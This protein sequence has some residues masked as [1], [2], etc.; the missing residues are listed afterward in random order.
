MEEFIRVRGAR[1]HNLKDIDLDIPRGKV[2]VVTGPSGSGKSSLVMDTIYAEGQRRYIESLSTYAKQFLEQI[3]KPDV[4]KVDGVSPAV[5][6]EQRNQVKTSRST[7]GTV[8]EVYDFMRILW[9]R[10]GRTFCPA[11]QLEVQPDTIDWAT[12]QVLEDFRGEAVQITFPL[13]LSRQIS[14]T[15]AVNNLQ[16]QGYLRVLADGQEVYLPDQ[17]DNPQEANPDIDITQA[18]ELLV[19]ADRLQVQDT[20]EARER[21]SDGLSASYAESHGLAVVINREG[22]RQKFSER[23]ECSRC[24]EEF[25]RP[26]PALFSFNSSRGACPECEGFGATLEYDPGLIVP[27]PEQTIRQGAIKVWE[28]PRYGRYKKH[29]RK[30]CQRH[31]INI[32]TPFRK[33]PA[34]KQELLLQGGRH[35]QGVIPFLE[36]REEKKY[37]RHIRFMLR[38]YQ[39]PRRCPLCAGE[40]LRSEALNVYVG[41]ENQKLTI[42]EAAQLKIDKL[43]DWLAN[44]ELEGFRQEVAGRLHSEL[45]SRIGFLAHVGLGYLTL[46]RQA[47]TL[48]G[49]EMQ[50]IR[51]ARCLGAGLTDTLYVLDEPTIGLHPADM[52]RFLEAMERF[53]ELGNTVLMVE[54]EPRVMKEAD[55]IV[56]L[57]P[58]SGEQGGEVVFEGT[59]SELLE[60]DTTTGQALRKRG[61]GI[62]REHKGGGTRKLSLQGASLHNIHDLDVQIPLERFVGVSG[63]SGSGKSTLVH[64]LL[65]HGLEKKLTGNVSAREHLG[66]DVGEYDQLTGTDRISEVVLVD[67]S[68]VGKS[69]RS[70]PATFVKAFGGIR[71]L[72]AGTEMARRRGFDQSAFSFNTEGGRC[73]ECKGTGEKEVDM[74][75]MADVSVPCQTCQGKRFHE[76]LLEVEYQGHNMHD[77]LQM[78]VDEAVKFFNTQDSIARSLWQLQRVGLGYIRLGQPIN[79]LSGGENQRLKIARELARASG[80]KG[81]FYILDEPTIGLG[82]S[83]ITQLVRWVISELVEAGHTVLVIEHNLDVLQSADW[84]IDLGPG[85]AEAGGEV[86]ACGPPAAIRENEHSR[87]GKYL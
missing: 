80:D 17:P 46:D 7:V 57:G 55:W 22:R 18:Q 2:T 40:R 29:M 63:V 81:R 77:I 82:L 31:D 86:V 33:L 9:A 12:Q 70:I 10:A 62:E 24:G 60:A 21:I 78:T 25:P 42:S 32:D 8:T 73:Q 79:T 65:F 19:V 38:R 69:K 14:H 1:Q 5:A 58:R 26:R 47:R 20:E 83:E 34:Q 39:S 48:S 52:E 76:E 11:C 45:S 56:E 61:K 41:N 13:E 6:I 68:P 64:D 59:Y 15:V 37:K 72:L 53:R 66:E 84:L 3:E 28:K 54:H 35:F 51:L 43:Y 49:G 71:K 87:T 23:F 4:D 75:F 67:Q 30:A 85:A 44:L 74:V 16:A 27:D 36:S 50:R